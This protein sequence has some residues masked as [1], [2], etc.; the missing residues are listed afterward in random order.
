M[1]EISFRI[2]SYKH[3]SLKCCKAFEA[4]MIHLLQ[5]SKQISVSAFLFNYEFLLYNSVAAGLVI[6]H[7]TPKSY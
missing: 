6:Q 2:L 5:N 4:V 7:L 3:V 1:I